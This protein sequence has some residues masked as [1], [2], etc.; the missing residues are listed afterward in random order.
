MIDHGVKLTREVADYINAT[1]GLEMLVDPQFASVL[2][3]VIPEIIQLNYLI[4]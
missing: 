2:F 3:R 4:L 1:A